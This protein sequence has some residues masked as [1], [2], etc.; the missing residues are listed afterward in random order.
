MQADLFSKP[1][2]YVIDS[3]CLMDVFNDT[4]WKSKEHNPG[5]WKRIEEL[6]LNGTIISHAEV[7][8]E[9]KTDGVKGEE[10]FTW[11]QKN[12]HIFKPH[13]VNSEGLIIRGM[14][15]KYSDF[16]NS[17]IDNCH[18]DPWLI[19]QAK[20]N[21]LKIITEETLSGSSD[22]KKF[23]IPNIC[24]DPDYNI[25]YLNLWELTIERGWKFHTH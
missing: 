16:V 2:E 3:C 12:S 8:C 13:N 17:K 6:I 21:N 18:A 25:K 4:P 10:L 19:A 11:A 14:T 23:N 24:K 1:A 5:L 22:P 9:I 20:N 7:L 15:A